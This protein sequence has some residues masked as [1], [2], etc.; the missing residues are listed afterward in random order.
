[1]SNLSARERRLVAL[2]I[3]VALIVL[4]FYGV[5]GPIVGGFADRAEARTLLL[6]RW[7]RDDRAIAQLADSRRIADAQRRD[8]G[9]FLLIAPTPVAAADR[10]RERLGAAVTQLGGELRGVEDLPPEPGI[11]RARVDARLTLAQAATL[12][13]RL[14]NEPPLLAVEDLALAV[15]DGAG[16]AGIGRLEVRLEV[17]ARA[18]A[19]R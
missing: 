2:L 6:E 7:S 15:E 11:V 3:L 19:P 14:Q 13:A 10:L 4:L 1:M 16:E 9:R 5:I 8:A 12:V 18:P 17:A